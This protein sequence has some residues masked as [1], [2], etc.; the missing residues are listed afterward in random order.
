MAE[1]SVDAFTSL[2]LSPFKMF[3][4]TAAP[5]PTRAVY[6]QAGLEMVNLATRR[7]QAMMDVTAKTRQ[8]KNSGDLANVAVEFWQTA[9]TQQMESASKIAALFG[10][11]ALPL[12][13]VAAK[14]APVRDVLDVQSASADVGNSN[15]VLDWNN[16]DRRAA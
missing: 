13:I 6:R 5:A 16:R 4:A 1:S 9:W 15:T 10:A 11:P 7:T 2:F 3:G 14:P 12:S 8:C